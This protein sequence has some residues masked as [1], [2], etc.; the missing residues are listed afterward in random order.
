MHIE[1]LLDELLW[2][3]LLPCDLFNT[4]GLHR[5]REWME[6]SRF[7]NH[8]EKADFLRAELVRQGILEQATGPLH[9]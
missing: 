6:W 8:V 4:T 1:K 9:A 5:L 3:W 7:S 2:K